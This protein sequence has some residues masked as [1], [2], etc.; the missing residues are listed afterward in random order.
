MKRILIIEDERPLAEAVAFSLEKEGYQVDIA[1]DG[2]SGWRKCREGEYDLVLL[3]LMLP[4]MDGMEICRELRKESEIPVIMLT[5]RDSDVDK[6]LGLEMGADDYVTKPFNMREL[7]ARVKAVLRRSEGKK[8][9]KEE[10]RLQAGEIVLDRERH[11]VTVRGRVVE[12]PLMEYRLLELFLRHPGKALP[13]EYL[14]SQVWEGDYY[15]QSKTLDVHIR[16]LREK[17][18]EDPARPSRIVTVRGVGY[19]FEAGGGET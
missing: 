3:D 2:E 14:I 6:V 12:M 4:G 7:V 11:E 17:I 15:G 19:R 16:R 5:A 1:L 13:R 18:E 8:G 10:A 9:G